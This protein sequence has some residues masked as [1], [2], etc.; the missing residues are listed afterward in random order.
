M[1]FVSIRCGGQL[2][3]DRC[4]FLCV[5]FMTDGLAVEWSISDLLMTFGD[6]IFRQGGNNPAFRLEF[7]TI[8]GA[9]LLICLRTFKI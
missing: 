4:L 2:S 9:K 3:L 7:M 6:E 8:D 5:R 1:R